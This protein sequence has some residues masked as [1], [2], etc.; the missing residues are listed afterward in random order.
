MKTNQF[1]LTHRIVVI[2][3]VLSCCLPAM[4]QPSGG[5][6]GPVPQTYDLPKDA[7]KIYYVSPDGNAEASGATL[8][9]STTIEE[10]L[11]RVVT[12]DAIILRGG[13]YRTGG[14]RFNQ[15]IIIQPYANEQPVFKGTKV[16]DKWEK[17]E[18]AGAPVWKTTWTR[19][20]PEKPADWWMPSRNRG[21]PLHRF[22]NDMV[23]IDGS[24]L[25]SAGSTKEVKENTYFIDYNDS[26]IYIGTDPT[27]RLV[28]IT[29]FNEALTR[30]TGSINGRPSDKKGPVLKGITFTQY[31]YRALE[32]E[33]KDPQGVSQE[34][35]HGKDIVGT[36]I[37]NC[38]ISFC[39]RV[40]AYLKGDKLVMRHCL[41]SDT[42]TEG[43]YIIASNDV[44]LEKNIFRRNNIENI[45]GYFPA[46]VKIFNQSH[47]VTCK[48][49][50]VTD[51][52][53]SNG[54]W[55]DVG[56]VD[57]I[58]I[59]NL[60][61]NVGTLVGRNIFDRFWPSNSGFF[62]EISKGAIVAGNVF[63]N[64][65]QGIRVLNSCNVQ[66]YNNTLVNS[67]VFF[68][69]DARGEGK[70]HFGWHPDT[71]ADVNSRDGHTFVNNL[72]VTDTSYRGPLF[73]FWQPPTLCQR[74]NKPQV[75]QLD[76]D[77]FVQQGQPNERL[78][79]WSPSPDPNC[80]TKYASPEDLHKGI[81]AFASNCKSF[82]DYHGPL[83]KDAAK[84][85]YQLLK[86]FPAAKKAAQLPPEIGRTLGLTQEKFLGIFP[87]PY[88][89]FVGAYEPAK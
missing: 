64:C 32:V 54:I 82:T 10:A 31:A 68:G 71:A 60:I 62:F 72:L 80:Q 75:K 22:N 37:E 23:F 5:P 16:A 20:F 46:D 49:N 27:N 38:T 52:P 12:G 78:I 14:L 81:P 50:L 35:K 55:Y 84:G 86:T 9:K 13:V 30:S 42:S 8:N 44:L 70:D 73:V 88:P 41:V 26:A 21:T 65:D 4:G 1:K 58:F 59:D 3:T 6:Y 36:V 53:N 63:V 28:E 25:Q 85:N 69:R 2:L 47:R 24:F 51:S 33:G 29:A 40:A 15:G 17:T 43:I 66:C 48:D 39:S 7:N 11:K 87:Q 79:Q 83:F 18:N 34:S 77:V 74:L 67:A 19:L 61:E 76:Y 45:S 89:R 57:G 56:N